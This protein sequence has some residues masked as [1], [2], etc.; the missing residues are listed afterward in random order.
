[1]QYDDLPFVAQL[2]LEWWAASGPKTK[3]RLEDIIA[4]YADVYAMRPEAVPELVERAWAKVPEWMK[5]KQS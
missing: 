5:E 4:H 1:V 2:G 3:A